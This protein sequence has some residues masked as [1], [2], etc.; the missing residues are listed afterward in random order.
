[1]YACYVHRVGRC[2]GLM[3]PKGTIFATGSENK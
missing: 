1:M 3:R 2:Q